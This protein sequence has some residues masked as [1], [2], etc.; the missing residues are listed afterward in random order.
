MVVCFVCGCVFVCVRLC[1]LW[2]TV[3][4]DDVFVSCVCCV[5][6]F[7]C[8]LNMFVCLVCAAWLF[9]A[10]CVCACVHGVS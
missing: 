2:F 10:F 3:M 4:L 8:A 6:V 1:V 5:C 9:F 7:V